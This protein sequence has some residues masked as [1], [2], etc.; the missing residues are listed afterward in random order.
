MF[1]RG[2]GSHKPKWEYVVS[3]TTQ[4]PIF[5]ADLDYPGTYSTSA[6]HHTSPREGVL[7]NQ[8]RLNRIS[9]PWE[10]TDTPWFKDICI[11]SSLL[12]QNLYAIMHN[13]WRSCAT[14]PRDKIFGTLGLAFGDSF[15]LQICQLGITCIAPSHRP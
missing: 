8:S 2:F 9:Y 14:D 11:G 6:T 1:L 12:F 3:P 7:V 15:A 4:T 13:T 10:T 5:P